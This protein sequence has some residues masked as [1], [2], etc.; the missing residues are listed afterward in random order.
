MEILSHNF[1]DDSD[2]YFMDKNGR[3]FMK[4]NL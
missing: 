2:P 4:P 1:Y 3:K